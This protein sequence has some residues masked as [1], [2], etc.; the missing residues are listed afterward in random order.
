MEERRRNNSEIVEYLRDIRESQIQH[1]LEFG[2][3]KGTI[4]GLAGPYGRI[5][6]L[7]KTN[8]RQW[9]VHALT[10]A[11]LAMYGVARKLGLAI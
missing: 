3:M 11:M 6:S 10:P 1:A 8:V 4:E 5:T 9:W 2:E 7:E